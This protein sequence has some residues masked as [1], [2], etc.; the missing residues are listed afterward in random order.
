MEQ[1]ETT[2]STRQVPPT[3]GL[4][5]WKDVI[6]KNLL[7]LNIDSSFPA[8]FAGQIAKHA[9]GPLNAN[10]ISVTEQRV[11]RTRHLDCGQQDGLFHLIHIRRGMQ[12]T[13]Q[14]G[15]RF[16]LEPGDCVLID[17]VASFDFQFPQ[18]VDA[19]VLEIPRNWI[20]GWLPVPEDAVAQVISGKTGWGGTLASALGN[21]C[22]STIGN[23]EL[24][25]ALI[26]EQIAVLLAL[27]AAPSGPAMRTGK[28]AMLQRVRSTLRER[29]HESHLDPAGVASTLRVSRRY[30]HALFASAGTTF[31]QELWNCRLQRAQRVLID[32][33]FAGVSIAE[34]AWNCG[35]TEPSHFTR[36]FR[37][38]FGV[39]PTTYRQSAA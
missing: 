25:P 9:F 13:E 30:I 24:A 11:W 16:T 5:Y 10:F 6:C 21:L 34:V 35:F 27:A 15:R 28:R 8:S 31:T 1:L 18:G 23:L 12:N 33:R 26:A 20:R 37:E 38:H 22:S 39:P 19:L 14:Y 36:R 17:C 2:W 4:S 7:E 29:C 3:E 32:K